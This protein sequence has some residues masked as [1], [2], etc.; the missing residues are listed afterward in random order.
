MSLEAPPTV[1]TRS[2]DVTRTIVA[3]AVASHRSRMLPMQSLTA[4]VCKEWSGGQSEAMKPCTPG[5]VVTTGA[6]VSS[7]KIREPQLDWLPAPST[8]AHVI[9]DEPSG[10]AE[11]DG[12]EHCKEAMPQ[13][14]VAVGTKLAKVASPAHSSLCSAG[15]MTTGGVMSTTVTV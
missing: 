12:G 14:S 1:S 4:I 2:S 7:T 5:L 3:V 15:Q 13:L 6:I 10:N 11:P 8:A 9:G